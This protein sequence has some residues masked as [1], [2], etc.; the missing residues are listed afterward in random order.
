MAEAATAPP[1]S[2]QLPLE[3]DEGLVEPG[4][5]MCKERNIDRNRWCER[6]TTS[7]AGW[8]WMAEFLTRVWRL[9]R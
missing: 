7:R 4:T 1:P 9:H 5:L 8:Y 2:S 6:M 3:D